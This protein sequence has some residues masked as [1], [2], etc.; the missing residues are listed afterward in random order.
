MYD[1]KYCVIENMIIDYA[2]GA[3]PN[4][5]GTTMAPSAIKFTVNF[6]EIEYWIKSNIVDP[7]YGSG[8]SLTTSTGNP[9]Q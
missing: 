7:A 9:N 3:T 8:I 5:Q 4:F 6:L 2:P 1:F